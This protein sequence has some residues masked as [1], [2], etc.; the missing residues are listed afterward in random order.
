LLL[1]GSAFIKSAQLGAHI[2]LPDSMEAPVP[3]SALIHSATLVSAGIFI[4]LRFSVIFENSC[5][6]LSIIFI[7]GA[8]TAAYGG[9]VAAFQTDCKK[10]LAYS[11][12]SH[13]GFLMV[14]CTTFCFEYVM[15]YLYV[16]GFFK[17][18]TFLSVGNILRFGRTQDYRRMGMFSKYLV[19][20][21]YAVFVGLLNL[22]GLPFSFGFYIKHL[23]FVGLNVNLQLFYACYFLCLIGAVS[24]L[25]YSYRL[26]Y[27]VFFDFK[28]A[29][30]ATYAHVTNAC[31]KSAYYTNAGVAGIL[32]I[33]GLIVTAYII[34][35]YLLYTY[36][37]MDNAFSDFLSYKS[38]NAQYEYLVERF[39]STRSYQIIN[40]TIV[41]LV[42]CILYTPWRTLA[43]RKLLFTGFFSAIL[44]LFF[45]IFALFLLNGAAFDKSMFIFQWWQDLSVNFL[46]VLFKPIYYIWYVSVN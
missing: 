16:H 41:S 9:I 14:L 11:T 28:K 6:L 37:S 26:Y 3:A 29:R 24:G 36:V 25:F 5:L 43:V 38:Y 15:L 23:L 27:Y 40:L 31:L 4:L 12:I 35:F 19:F 7:V 20:D 8:T 39:Q 45:F 10:L 42:L 22:A 18:S 46:T 44:C 34:C 33:F 13:C 17:A 2:W 21:S 30:K 32:S 1:L